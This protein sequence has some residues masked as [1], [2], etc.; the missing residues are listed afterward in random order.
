MIVESEDDEIA[1]E[2]IYGDQ[3][4]VLAQLGRIDAAKLPACG[5]G[6]ARKV[7]DPASAPSNELIRRPLA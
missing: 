5:A 1:A 6:A 4:T 7:L 3:A 2:R